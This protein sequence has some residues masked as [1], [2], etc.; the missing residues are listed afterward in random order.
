MN[1]AIEESKIGATTMIKRS[2]TLP[3]ESPT[4]IVCPEPNFKPSMSRKYNLSNPARDLFTPWMID[5][6]KPFIEDTFQNRTVE[7]LY[8]ELSYSKNDLMFFYENHYLKLG[9][10]ELVKWDGNT[11][12]IELKSLPTFY[13][14]QCFL[15]ELLNA[16]QWTE[17]YSA[18]YFGYRFETSLLSE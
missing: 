9:K 4:I 13:Y 8:E 11:V 17:E 15:I 1:E 3:L 6:V 7:D 10:N 18:I 16:N 2:E 5:L 12:V 14:G